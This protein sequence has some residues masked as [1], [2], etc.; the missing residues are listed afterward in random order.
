MKAIILIRGGVEEPNMLSEW[1]AC[2]L[3][4]QGEGRWEMEGEKNWKLWEEG[5]PAVF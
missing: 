1:A 4:A 5:V 3:T 2:R